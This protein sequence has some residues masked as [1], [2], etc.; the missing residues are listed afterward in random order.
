MLQFYFA[1]TVSLH[2]FLSLNSEIY[3]FLKEWFFV[4]VSFT[5]Y[6]G[7]S[8]WV[9]PISYNSVSKPH[10]YEILVDIIY[11]EKW[12]F[13]SLLITPYFAGSYEKDRAIN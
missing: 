6:Y 1:K 12:Y 13:H 4:T 7:L 3:I 10:G 8:Y 9:P 5:N 11:M 2:Q